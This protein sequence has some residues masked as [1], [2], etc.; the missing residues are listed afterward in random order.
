VQLDAI[1]CVV[2]ASR[3]ITDAK[4]RLDVVR[5]QLAAAQ[6][7]VLNKTDLVSSQE[8]RKVETAMR[9]VAHNSTDE[10]D[11]HVYHAVHADLAPTLLTNTG[12]FSYNRVMTL[13]SWPQQRTMTSPSVACVSC[14]VVR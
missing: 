6:V 14:P 3:L 13:P 10:L 1:V 11:A 5:A 9:L 12:L 4:S 8:L 7:V 2:D